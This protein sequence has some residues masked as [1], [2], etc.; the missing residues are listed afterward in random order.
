MPSNISDG[1]GPPL[2]L[3]SMRLMIPPL[4][5]VSGAIWQTVQRRH[6]MDYGVLE[7]FVTMV[8]EMVPELLTHR[9]RAQLILGLQARLVL[10]LCRSEPTADLRTIQ[11][12]LDR[13][14]TVT[15]LWGAQTGDLELSGSNFLALIENLLEDP[16]EMEH[17]FQE[18]F[19]VEFGPDY[20]AE[21]EI[22]MWKFLSRLEELLPVSNFQQAALLL[23]EVPSILEECVESVSDP[24]HLKTLIQYHRDLC[25]LDDYA[26]QPSSD[27]ECILSALC[28]SHVERRQSRQPDI[29]LTVDSVEHKDME[30]DAGTEE[31]NVLDVRTAGTEAD[32]FIDEVDPRNERLIGYIREDG[33]LMPYEN[34]SVR[35][36]TLKKPQIG[37]PD[38]KTSPGDCQPSVDLQRLDSMI[39]TLTPVRSSTGIKTKNFLEKKQ[40]KRNCRQVP[41]CGSDTSRRWKNNSQDE[42]Y[43]C[44]YCTRTYRYLNNMRVHE[45]TCLIENGPP[46]KVSCQDSA[47]PSGT[48]EKDPNVFV[49]T[50]HLPFA[51][52]SDVE[53][54]GDNQETEISQSPVASKPQGLLSINT[55]IEL[56]LADKILRSHITLEKKTQRKK[57]IESLK[58]HGLKCEEDSN[59]SHRRSAAGDEGTLEM[60][61]VCHPEVSSNSQE[62]HDNPFSEPELNQTRTHQHTVVESQRHLPI[63]VKPRIGLHPHTCPHCQK[64]F[65]FVRALRTHQLTHNPL[66]CTLCRMKFADPEKLDRHKLVAHK[67]LKCT[68]CEDVFD[69]IK[70]LNQHYL[71][72]HEFSGPFLC[73]YCQKGFSTLSARVTHERTHTGDLPYQCSQCPKKYNKSADLVE[74]RKL[75]T[76]E[77]PCLCWECGQAFTNEMKLRNHM[78][79]VHSKPQHPCSQCDKCYGEKRTLVSHV[80]TCHSGVRYPCAR[81]AKTFTSA[82]SLTIHER[83]HSQQKPFKCPESECGKDFRS[84]K[85]LTVHV[86]YH[87]G[88]RP[89]SCH[90]CGKGFTQSCYLTQHMRTHTGEKPYKCSVCG[91][92][93]NDS[94]KLKRH[95]MTHTKEKPYKCSRC[96][97]AFCRP[98]LLKAHDK[99]EHVAH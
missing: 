87:T 40:I 72:V 51:G 42:V 49:V 82:S 63:P 91:R 29:K 13:I 31:E 8:T 60:Y 48:T 11:P 58:N 69:W 10:E 73:T 84:K 41:S 78:L 98:D 23:G 99:K 94:R 47:S 57:D 19:P 44:S 35:N 6:V 37:L 83:I 59:E 20:D 16:G 64:K 46:E 27:G 89:F 53:F 66:F 80:K 56:S 67:P 81:C 70:P 4:R 77:K 45:E 50:Q 21:I 34:V 43:R 86:R 90:V 36:K 12:H 65:M 96:D 61:S 97:K 62:E 74:H 5:L 15:P 17:F 18:V 68:M 95:M 9:Q 14:Q 75:H 88:E 55:P 39:H 28:C 52:G 71:N 33:V 3:P 1:K 85:E 7:E 32:S 92:S 25:L 24:Q 30:V 22:L 26:T 38:A 54:S 76:G 2:P 93:F 79:N